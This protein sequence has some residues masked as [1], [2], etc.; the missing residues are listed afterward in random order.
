MTA[1]IAVASGKGG[2]GKTALAIALSQ[3]FAHAGR[4]TLLVD[5]DLGLANVD[6]QLGLAPEGDL[7]SVASGRM[8]MEDAVASYDDGGRGGFDVLPGNS[9]AGALRGLSAHEVMRLGQSMHLIAAR[10]DRTVVDLGAGI[11]NTV[12]DLAAFCGR[13]LVVLN[14]EPT[15]LT[16]AYALIKVLSQ[17]PG[18][19]RLAIC[20]NGAADAAE[21]RRTYAAI[22]RACTRFLGAA[23][24]LAGIVRHDD[25]M[26][27]AIRAQTAYL[28]RYPAGDTADDLGRLAAGVDS[29]FLL[30]PDD[31][32]VANRRG[33]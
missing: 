28:S 2:V 18:A 3:C 1:L 20:V 12:L 22:E 8:T 29:V 11:E 19:P 4:R 6:V 24:P 7:L 30:Q 9:G 23:P 31:R 15:A 13:V 14:D 32:K 25:R 27:Q 21:G 26:R 5:G 17:R 10:Y 16:D 33:R